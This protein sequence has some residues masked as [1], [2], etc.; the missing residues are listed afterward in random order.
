M[1][2]IKLKNVPGSNL[3]LSAMASGFGQ[4][5]FDLYDLSG[6][7]K[8]YT[9]PTSTGEMIP[10]RIDC[11]DH[12]F[13]VPWLY[14]HSLPE[15]LYNWAQVNPNINNHYPDAME[16]SGTFWL[17]DITNWWGQ[18]EP[19]PMNAD[20]STEACIISFVISPGVGMDPSF[21]LQRDVLG[22]R[23]SNIT[24]KTL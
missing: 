7:N 15:S 12:I 10:G 4:S 13:T 22:W 20:L 2:I 18:E 16:I 14:L 1:S 17:P 23:Q 11:T 6:D 24:S 21:S 9:M 19:N 8:E 3:W 5:T